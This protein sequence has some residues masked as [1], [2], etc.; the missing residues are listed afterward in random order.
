MSVSRH[1]QQQLLRSITLRHRGKSM[2]KVRASLAS[3]GV[4]P[5]LRIP[6]R[7]LPQRGDPQQ[8]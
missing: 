5:T 1:A 2:H 6:L 4:A 3:G 8:A 7:V